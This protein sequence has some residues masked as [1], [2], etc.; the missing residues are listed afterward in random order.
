MAFL[1]GLSTRKALSNRFIAI[2]LGFIGLAIVHLLGSWRYAYLANI[3]FGASFLAVSMPY[4]IK[5]IISI[6][7]AQIVAS[8]MRKRLSVLR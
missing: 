4:L 7:L 6:I 5:D 1:C 2:A 3:S 8:S